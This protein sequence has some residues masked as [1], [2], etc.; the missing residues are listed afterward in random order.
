MSFWTSFSSNRR[1]ISRLT[2]K[3]VF[4]AL[5]TAC[6]FAGA[7]TRISPSS[8]YATTD[9]VVRA[10]FRVFDDLRLPALH[11]GDAAVGGA[12]VDADDLAHETFSFDADFVA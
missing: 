9:G 2:A 10:A 7:P 12:E 3:I 11:D 5:V 8:A 6:R 1:P 4:L